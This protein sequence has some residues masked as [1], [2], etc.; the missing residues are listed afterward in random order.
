[1]VHGKD[2]VGWELSEAGLNQ[3]GQVSPHLT[4]G[5]RLFISEL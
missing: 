2:Q 5:V 4:L 1:M 3:R